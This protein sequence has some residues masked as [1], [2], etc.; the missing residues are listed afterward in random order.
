MATAATMAPATQQQHSSVRTMRTLEGLRGP[1][2]AVL[3]ST[4]N[5]RG[6]DREVA[7]S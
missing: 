7:S 2:M 6:P 4:D 1:L 3:F 5:L